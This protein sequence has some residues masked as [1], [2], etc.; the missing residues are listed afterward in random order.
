MT[1]PRA[2]LLWLFPLALPAALAAVAHC[3]ARVVDAVDLVGTTDD[4]AVGMGVDAGTGMGADT[5]TGMGADTSTAPGTPWPN[6]TNS[7]NSDPWIASNHDTISVMQP[8]LLVLD[9]YNP[10]SL[11]L[12]QAQAKNRIAEI[13]ESSRY[14]GYSDSTARPFLNYTLVG[15]GV[16]DLTDYPRPPPTT[17]PDASS[18]LPIVNG[19]FD[20][21]GLF[22]PAFAPYYGFPDPA[23]ASRSLTLCELFERGIINE[24]WLITG[25]EGTPRRPPLLLESKQVYDPQNQAIAGTFDGCTGTVCWPTA[26]PHCK[27]TTRIAHLSATHGVGCDLVSYSVGIEKTALSH[28]IP[29]LYDN[30]KHFFNSDFGTRYGTAFNSWG[31]L[32]AMGP[33]GS[34]WC[35][36]SSPATACINYPGTTVAQYTYP[37]L[38]GG[39][40]STPSTIPSFDQ[41][42]GTAHFPPNARFEW[43]YANS[44]GVQSR[45]ENY[46]MQNGPAGSDRTDV[47][48]SAKEL[49]SAP[50]SDDECAGGW[51]IYHR[52][53]MP[54]LHNLAHAVDGTP[55]RNWWPFLF[56]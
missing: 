20:T 9:F 45:C 12:A 6:A 47:Y 35:T 13:A 38:D 23:N 8:R 55:M 56:Y 42:C 10:W 4:G 33:R 16:V 14:H 1:P 27:V 44:Q 3:G 25:D 29:Y 46:A 30:A 17:S 24:L 52:R 11:Q 50:P 22:T 15:V 41:G 48:T 21:G 34:G 37:P 7:A 19:A 2:R 43:D 31:E 54:G 5:G 32:V 18:R 53:S 28:A 26:A 40:G 39:T 51:Q 49:A 36:S